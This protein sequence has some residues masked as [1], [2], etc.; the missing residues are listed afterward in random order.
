MLADGDCSACGHRYLQ[1]LPAGHGL[2]YPAALDLDTG[3]VFQAGYGPWFA[4]ALRPMWETPDTEPA[5]LTVER[6][7]GARPA[8]LL[9]CLDKIYGHALLKLLNVGRHL[10]DEGRAVIVVIPASLRELVPEGVAE[11]WIVDAPTCR[12]AG[13]LVDLEA[14]IALELDRVGDCLL[15]PAFP[16]P[17][18]STY[19]LDTLLG[20]LA[21]ERVGDP[22]IVLS[23]RADRSWGATDRAQA[24]NVARLWER[25]ASAFPG[26]GCTAVGAA[27]PG[28]LPSGIA[29]LTRS[30]PD[31]ETE[32]RWLGLLR[33]ADLVIGVH[34][35]NLLLPSGLARASIE[36]LPEERYGNALQATLPSSLDPVT[37]LIRH[38]T[39][40]GADDL[41]DV[42]PERVAAVAMSVLRERE[43]M[44]HVLAGPAAGIGDAPADQHSPY[45][46]RSGAPPI[47]SR[48]VVRVARTVGRASTATRHRLAARRER[49]RARQIEVPTVVRDERGF[50]FEFE[51]RDE[52]ERFLVNGG[53]FEE[54]ELTLLTAY[55]DHGMT[56]FDVGANI[57]VF[58]A[59]FAGAVGER[60]AVHSFEPLPDSRRRLQRTVELND[61]RQVVVNGCAVAD[62]TGSVELHDYGPG[63]ETW[64]S[65]APRE[66][67]TDQGVV[68]TARRVAVDVVTL[69]E[70]CGDRGVEH[71]DVLKVDVEGAEEHV[72]RGAS[73]L[74]EG[75]AVDLVMVEVADTTLAAAGSRAHDLLDVLERFG[76]S[77]YALD[78]LGLRPHRV[79]G[80]QLT[81]TNVVA[82]SARARDRLRAQSRVSR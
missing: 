51:T 39:L 4:D 73:A 35:S 68:R 22:S 60:G 64:A 61:L 13:W 81:L 6:G 53:Q 48:K 76:F 79:A 59:A 72:L 74:L 43:R 27:A 55:L 57:G 23:L 31:R 30:D 19:S 28:G 8:V 29:D 41:G 54:A 71:V 67:A 38:R 2:M 69:D 7:D 18:P 44:E 11:T 36:L 62:R 80:Q 15:S 78:G 63:Y 20:E 12:F 58:T 70:Y 45:E 21:P 82:A 49:G 66:I 33:G 17:H 52:L 65:L 42:S 10:E 25:L 26:A 56:A 77:T 50:A 32:R 37:A 9:N 3:E 24:T 5:T 16:H 34:G 47:V 14:R 1:D 46:V 40:Y 75:G